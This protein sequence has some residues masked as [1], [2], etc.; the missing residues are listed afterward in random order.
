MSSQ[1]HACIDHQTKVYPCYAQGWP[2]LVHNIQP[3]GKDVRSKPQQDCRKAKCSAK[4]VPLLHHR[5]Y[6]N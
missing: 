3:A 2:R 4:A 5:Q 6:S 1:K